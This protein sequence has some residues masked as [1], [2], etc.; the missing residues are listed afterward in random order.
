MKPSAVYQY[1]LNGEL[2]SLHSL[3]VYW[4]SSLFWLAHS[5]MSQFC[6]LSFRLFEWIIWIARTVQATALASANPSIAR[7]LPP[8]RLNP[9]SDLWIVAGSTPRC[10]FRYH[11]LFLIMIADKRCCPFVNPPFQSMSIVDTLR[12]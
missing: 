5:A 1:E 6:I 7:E 2:T 9:V 4:I 10:I 11:G 3:T 12:S 8:V